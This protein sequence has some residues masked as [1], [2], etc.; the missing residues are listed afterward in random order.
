MYSDDCT[1]RKT[2]PLLLQNYL[3]RKVIRPIVGQAFSLE[4]V[5]I[6]HEK[7]MKVRDLQNPGIGK[8][9]L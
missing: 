4:Q 3:S 9:K 2:S 8:D 7:Y 6:L 5:K 1:T